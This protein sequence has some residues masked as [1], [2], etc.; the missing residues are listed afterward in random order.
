MLKKLLVILSIHTAAASATMPTPNTTSLAISLAR[1]SS[2]SSRAGSA[3]GKKPSGRRQ[4]VG[5]LDQPGRRHDP[6]GRQAGSS[7]RLA[8]IETSTVLR[9]AVMRNSS[10]R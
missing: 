9:K 2:T 3:G 1:A 5:L 10:M 7:S 6:Q 8:R 4:Q